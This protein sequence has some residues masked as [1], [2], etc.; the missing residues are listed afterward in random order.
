M[1]TQT[2]M[3]AE[4]VFDGCDFRASEGRDGTVF[5]FNG[6]LTTDQI[7]DRYFAIY[8]EHRTQYPYAV[9]PDSVQHAWHLFTAHEDTCYLIAEAD[10]DDPFTD[11]ELSDPTFCSCAAMDNLEAGTGYEY[12][13]PYPAEA[14]QPGAVPVTWATI[15]PA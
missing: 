4:K 8:P 13:H 3:T 7:T 14:G 12:R 15:H 6:H 2:P 10:P 1:T 11:D 5:F 9:D